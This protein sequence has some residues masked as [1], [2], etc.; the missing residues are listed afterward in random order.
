MA[1]AFSIYSTAGPRLSVDDLDGNVHLVIKHENS[2]TAIM[3]D[4]EDLARAL[5][6]A[7]PAFAQGVASIARKVIIESLARSQ[8]A[9]GT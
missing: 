8:D 1:D 2:Q 4:G 5:I 3:L 6:T 7:S 9:D